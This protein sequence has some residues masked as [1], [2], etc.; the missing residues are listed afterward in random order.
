MTVEIVK[1]S[2]ILPWLQRFIFIIF[3]AKGRGKINLWNQGSPIYDVRWQMCI[4]CY[5]LCILRHLSVNN[6]ATKFASIFSHF[7][8]V[9]RPAKGRQKGTDR[10]HLMI[11]LCHDILFIIVQF[12]RFIWQTIFNWDSSLN[13]FT[14]SITIYLLI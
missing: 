8:S 9:N 6:F 14:H 7:A 13:Q 4:F 5:L 2:P 10:R 12:G 1:I 11:Q 3:I